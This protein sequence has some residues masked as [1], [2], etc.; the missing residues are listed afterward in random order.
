MMKAYESAD[1][2]AEMAILTAFNSLRER[3]AYSGLLTVGVTDCI[4]IIHKYLRSE[5]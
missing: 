4:W 3:T 2:D 1:M 5:A